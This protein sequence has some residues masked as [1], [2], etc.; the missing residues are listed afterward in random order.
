MP[1]DIQTTYLAIVVSIACLGVAA[2]FFVRRWLRRRHWVR[3]TG[4]VLRYV[5]LNAQGEVE[6]ELSEKSSI[7]IPRSYIQGSF[8][9]PTGDVQLF[10]TVWDADTR[11]YG[12]GQKLPVLYNP[13]NPAEAEFDTIV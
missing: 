8:I 2:F 1:R 7:G 11:P 4:T 9:G 6:R 10:H 13:A 5:Q 12:V 3:V